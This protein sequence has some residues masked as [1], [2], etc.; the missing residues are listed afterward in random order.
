MN[1][2]NAAAYLIEG[3][4]AKYFNGFMPLLREIVGTVESKTQEQMQLRARAMESMGVL[5]VSVAENQEFLGTVQEVTQSLFGLLQQGFAE[6]DPQE[7]AVKDTLA[8]VAFYL[9]GDFNAVAPQ[10]L[11]ILLKDASAEVKVDVNAGVLPNSVADKN[12][13]DIKIR[14]LEDV[15][16]FSLNTGELEQKIA[17]FNHIM[18]VASAM[19]RSFEP[20]IQAVLPILTA[21]MSNTSRTLRK[22]ALKTF[23]HLL[24]AQGEPA[25]LALFGTIYEHFALCI[26]KAKKDNNVKEMKLLYKELLHCLNVI[27]E[28]EEPA[29]RMPLTA[30]KLR[31]FAAVM[32]SCLDTVTQQTQEARLAIDEKQ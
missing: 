10:F 15:Q 21:H 13:I 23:Q 25:N 5:I 20:H 6:D 18:K 31:T 29:N 17:A 1:L 11:A 30:D 27:G 4:F 12:T 14:G 7:L 3:S 9:K 2:L 22:Y 16:R 24:T 19:G 28:N 8:K 26:L 32:K